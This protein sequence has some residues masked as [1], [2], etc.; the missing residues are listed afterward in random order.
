MNF[1]RQLLK[2]RYLHLSKDVLNMYTFKFSNI[3]TLKNS[4]GK[5]MLQLLMYSKFEEYLKN[6][7]F[8]IVL[9]K[10]Q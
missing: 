3:V 5:I 7:L 10:K 2:M 8:I 4:I 9:F 6:E 1:P